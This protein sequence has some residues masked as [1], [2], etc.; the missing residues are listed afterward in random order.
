MHRS[1]LLL[2]A[3]FCGVNIALVQTVAQAKTKVEIG[4]I[5]KSIT[6]RIE[7]VD[8][9]EKGSG[10]LLQKQGDMYTVL[11]AAHVV[12]NAEVF[13]VITPDGNVHRSISVRTTSSSLDLAVIKFRSNQIY[14]LAKIGT[15]NSLEV[16][17]EIYVAG[18]PASTRTVVNGTLQVTPG[19]VTGN[20]TRPDSSGYSLIYNSITQP[21][22]SGGA[23]LNGD[24]RLVAMHG[25][26]DK[27]TDGQKTGFNL[28]ITIERFG[29]VAA[30]L[31]AN[32]GNQIATVSLSTVPKAA[33]FL[34]SATEKE[35]AGNYQGA[36]RDYDQAIAIDSRYAE[37]YLSRGSLKNY[38]FNDY[39]GASSDYSEAIRINPQHFRAYS[40]RARLRKNKLKDFR[41]ALYD[42]NKWI[43]LAPNHGS[44]VIAYNDRGNLKKDD[45]NDIIGALADY[46]KAIE[47]FPRLSI[48]YSNRG[49]LKEYGLNDLSGALADY[50]KAIELDP[51]DV[52]NYK[53]RAWLKEKKDDI[54]GALS[55]YDKAIEVQSS[56]AKGYYHRGILKRDKL[57]HRIGAIQDF[58]QAA[59]LYRQQNQIE[60][61]KKIIKILNQLGATE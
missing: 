14:Q 29:T 35:K 50:S 60:E 25:R 6:L 48:A 56:F 57:K 46:N 10:I 40:A 33:D 44:I 9:S 16:G 52:E 26:G 36:L 38:Q 1:V 59:R 18:F 31:G 5:A 27:D 20:A 41:G 32:I 55:D 17:S 21:G 8:T 7:S 4:R 2:P 15:S 54:F 19:D 23:V 24:G 58:R 45:L 61:L 49:T 13:R 42:F 28:G 53:Y 22:M 34:L 30:A 3:I 39:T 51:K 11:T 37:A 43:E 47:L 12:K